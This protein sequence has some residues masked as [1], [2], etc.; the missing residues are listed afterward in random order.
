MLQCPVCDTALSRKFSYDTI[1]E[2]ME[3]SYECPQCK[4]VVTTPKSIKTEYCQLTL[5]LPLAPPN[6]DVV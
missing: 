4:T 1:G 5:P 2:D 3:S 6:I